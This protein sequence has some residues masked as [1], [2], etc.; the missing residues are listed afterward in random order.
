MAYEQGVKLAMDAMHVEGPHDHVELKLEHE[1]GYVAKAREYADKYH[2]ALLTHFKS[3]HE[4]KTTK[5]AFNMDLQGSPTLALAGMAGGGALGAGIG[6][7][8]ADSGQR[9]EGARK[10]FMYG[11]PLGGMAGA[12]GGAAAYP[13]SGNMGTI[14]SGTAGGALGG[15]LSEY[16]GDNKDPQ[17]REIPMGVRTLAG[18]NLGAQLGGLWGTLVR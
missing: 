13:Q 8:S 7:L 14:L 15:G 4:K 16:L 11:F 2:K 3:E 12:I 9:A 6:A 5:V 10:G 17:G 1:P 18:A